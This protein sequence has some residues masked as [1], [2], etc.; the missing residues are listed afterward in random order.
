MRN[1][2]EIWGCLHQWF[3]LAQESTFIANP[4]I[5]STYRTLV[6]ITELPWSKLDTWVQR[7]Q[8]EVAV[9]SPRC[10]HVGSGYLPAASL[11]K[12]SPVMLPRLLTSSVHV[13]W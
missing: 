1:E 9:T 10:V 2:K 6:P 11:C 12:S 8:L 4:L 7:T 5:D 3:S 13:W